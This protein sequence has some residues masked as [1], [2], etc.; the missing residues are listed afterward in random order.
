L[1]D[2]SNI[3]VSAHNMGYSAYRYSADFPA[4]AM[5][6]IHL[7]GYTPEEDEA[8]SDSDAHIAGGS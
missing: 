2:A 5:G 8:T 6:E 4:D 1:C 3:V 7:G